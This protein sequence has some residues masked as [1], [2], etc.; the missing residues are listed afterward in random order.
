MAHYQKYVGESEK[1]NLK[2]QIAA[3][4][5][6]E[7]FMGDWYRLCN[8]VTQLDFDYEWQAIKAKH[9]FAVT[10]YMDK[11][12]MPHKERFGKAWTRHIPHYNLLITS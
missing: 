1:A 3:S 12:W 7:D 10:S 11:T 6:W 8:T 5:G 4:K 9:H 2:K